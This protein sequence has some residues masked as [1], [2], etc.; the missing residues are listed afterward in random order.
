M[1]RNLLDRS[2]T[3]LYNRSEP[4]VRSF[5]LGGAVE[6][7]IGQFIPALGPLFHGAVSFD[8][9]K[10]LTYSSDKAIY[11]AGIE[12]SLLSLLT[13]RVGCIEDKQGDVRGRTY[14]GGVGLDYHEPPQGSHFGT[15]VDVA[16][17]PQARGLDRE[18]K[19][20]LSAWYGF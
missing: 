3:S 6:T 15:R 18:W 12:G 1:I 9:E 16:N 11:N 17:V 10:S 5:R 7:G 20:T 14:G 19:F 8:I 2:I 4:L 13:L